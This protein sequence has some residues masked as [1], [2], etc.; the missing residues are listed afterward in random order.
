MMQTIVMDGFRE[1]GLAT[2]GGGAACA[3]MPSP[4]SRMPSMATGRPARNRLRVVPRGVGLVLPGSLDMALHSVRCGGARTIPLAHR[5]H[6]DH[7][8]SMNVEAADAGVSGVA[9]AIAEPAR[10]RVLYCLM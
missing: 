8:E 7:H 2:A 9:A 4:N 3:S 6:F 1:G 5:A 10:P